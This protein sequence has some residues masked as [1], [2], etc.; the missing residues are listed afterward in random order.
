MK[1]PD[2]KGLTFNDPTIDKA[3]LLADGVKPRKVVVT[4]DGYDSTLNQVIAKI[5][6]VHQELKDTLISNIHKKAEELRSGS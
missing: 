2:L 3:A 5:R 6:V 1:Q 4:I